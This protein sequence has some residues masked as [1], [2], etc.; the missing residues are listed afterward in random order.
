MFI[1][2]GKGSQGLH[3]PQ[4]FQARFLIDEL[5]VWQVDKSANGDVTKKKLFGVMASAGQLRPV[6]C[7]NGRYGEKYVPLTDADKQWQE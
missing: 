5:D 1:P 3:F 4:N 7:A 2:V 6:Y